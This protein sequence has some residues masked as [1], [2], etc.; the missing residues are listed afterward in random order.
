LRAVLGLC[1]SA[2]LLGGALGFV[3]ASIS[4]GGGIKSLGMWLS[5]ESVIAQ[6]LYC[7]L[8]LRSALR[9]GCWHNDLK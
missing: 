4:S 1:S 9:L 7:Q 5:S 2:F 6:G 3:P 8:G